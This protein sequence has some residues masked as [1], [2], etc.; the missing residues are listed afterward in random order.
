MFCNVLSF[1][2]E[3]PERRVDAEGWWLFKASAIRAD[4]RVKGQKQ[5]DFA[6]DEKNATSDAAT[7]LTIMIAGACYW[8][9][10]KII[11]KWPRHFV[12][13]DTLVSVHRM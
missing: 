5:L 13:A 10:M 3:F 6:T 12:S 9:W 7:R 8:P 1:S 2:R 11:L 4:A